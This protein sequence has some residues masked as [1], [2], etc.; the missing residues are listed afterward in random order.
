MITIPDEDELL[1]L[2]ADLFDTKRN[3]DPLERSWR[4]MILSD[5][6]RDC[7]REIDDLGLLEAGTHL[8]MA[9]HAIE[10]AREPDRPEFS[11]GGSCPH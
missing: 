10:K 11:S 3:I 2:L 4:A 9:L 8:D 5:R 6:L 1:N 7:L